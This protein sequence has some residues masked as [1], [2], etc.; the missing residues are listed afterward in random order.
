M[1]TKYPPQKPVEIPT[2]DSQWGSI[3]CAC[4]A[5]PECIDSRSYEHHRRRRYRCPACDRRW[6]TC[7]VVIQ[8]NGT[9]RDHDALSTL[10]GMFEK[11][12][13]QNLRMKIGHLL[14][15]PVVNH[16]E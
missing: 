2:A 15:E 11:E 7:E 6:T 10:R 12:A 14:G 9:G 3:V 5:K 13:A 1:S 8:D 16:H 4:T